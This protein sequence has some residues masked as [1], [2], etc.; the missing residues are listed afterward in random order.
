MPTWM[1]MLTVPPLTGPTTLCVCDCAQN[2]Q[3]ILDSPINF[4]RVF[5]VDMYIVLSMGYKHMNKRWQVR[6][7]SV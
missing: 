5:A 2:N 3:S 6:A 1:R 7:L 4:A